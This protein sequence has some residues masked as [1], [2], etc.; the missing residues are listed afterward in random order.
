M[1]GSCGAGVACAALFPISLQGVG[2]RRGT[3]WVLRSLDL[4]S[5]AAASPR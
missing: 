1:N 4:Q 5:R 2:L 3:N